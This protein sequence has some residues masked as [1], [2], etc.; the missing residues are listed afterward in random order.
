MLTR[1]RTRVEVGAYQFWHADA[2]YFN[3]IDNYL[4]LLVAPSHLQDECDSFI[5][6]DGM[7]MKKNAESLCV[8]F[9]NKFF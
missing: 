8:S 6:F 4:A 1:L 3:K 2:V 9:E 7:F 5:A